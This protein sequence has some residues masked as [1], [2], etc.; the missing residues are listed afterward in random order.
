MSTVAN[1][2]I[3]SNPVY[4]LFDVH[5]FVT[6]PPPILPDC[7]CRPPASHL[8]WSQLLWGHGTSFQTSHFYKHLLF[9][10]LMAVQNVIMILFNCASPL[11]PYC[12]LYLSMCVE[13]C[14]VSVPCLVAECE[15]ADFVTGSSSEKIPFVFLPLAGQLV[16]PRWA[17]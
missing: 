9:G 4:R 3:S 7:Y 5:I 14:T 6:Y 12:N 17:Y 13:C 15:M 1:T 16:N 10:T 11:L 2:G 8:S